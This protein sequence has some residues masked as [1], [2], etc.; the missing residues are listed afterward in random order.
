MIL[1]AFT[2]T[3]GLAQASES[4]HCQTQVPRGTA[5]LTLINRTAGVFI[6]SFSYQNDDSDQTFTGTLFSSA[7]R[8]TDTFG[9]IDSGSEK[10]EIHLQ[11][12]SE[13]SP[14][15]GALVARTEQGQR[16]APIDL[17]FGNPIQCK[18][19]D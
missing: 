8:I 4:Y 16:F 6:W 3:A 15:N 9:I 18:L 14:L 11:G 13:A 5:T 10:I 2:L 7:E 12:E 17:G 1:I 19:K